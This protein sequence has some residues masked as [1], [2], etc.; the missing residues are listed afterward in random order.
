M[1]FCPS[2]TEGIT[3]AGD[4]KG[5]W[6]PADADSK[7]PIEAYFAPAPA[8]APITTDSNAEATEAP[9]PVT[10]TDEKKAAVVI[11][12]DAFGFGIQNPKI[13]ADLMAQKTGL[14]VWVPDYFLGTFKSLFQWG[15]GVETERLSILFDALS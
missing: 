8:P 11:L 14:D 9:A 6:I 5:Q 4:P 15:L 3:L 10:A 2:C 12:M 1:D 13:I 7:L